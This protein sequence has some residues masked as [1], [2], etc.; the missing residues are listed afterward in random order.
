MLFEKKMEQLYFYSHKNT[1]LEV[2]ILCRGMGL[3]GKEKASC[4][5]LDV[6]TTIKS[7]CDLLRVK[8]KDKFLNKQN[9]WQRF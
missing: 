5:A 7:Y 8:V 3:F 2:L 4:P 1:S 6:F 9:I